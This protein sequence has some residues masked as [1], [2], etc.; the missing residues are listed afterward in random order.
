[1]EYAHRMW[2]RA[3]GLAFALPATYF[4]ARGMLVGRGLKIRVAGYAGLILFQVSTNMT[5]ISYIDTIYGNMT[6]ISYLDTIYGNM[7]CQLS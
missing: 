4:W 1:M 6:L 7:T 5:L 3:V 2:G